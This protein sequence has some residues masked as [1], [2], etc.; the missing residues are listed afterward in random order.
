L[1]HGLLI[2]DVAVLLNFTSAY[3]SQLEHGREPL[4]AEAAMAIA[5]WAD[6]LPAHPRPIRSPA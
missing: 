1:A 6:E 4:T 3:L 5:T 2:H